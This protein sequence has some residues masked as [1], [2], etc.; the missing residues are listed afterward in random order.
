MSAEREIVNLWLNRRGFF[1]IAG[2]N[3]G[4]RVVD[5]VAIRHAQGTTEIMHVEVSCSISANALFEKDRAELKKLFY[6]PSIVKAVE[7][8]ISNF[9]GENHSYQNVLVTNFQGIEIDGVRVIKF[10]D[11]FFDFLS[12]LD[13]QRYYS[14]T[15]RGLQL[16]KFLLMSDP[17]K[18]SALLNQQTSYRPMTSSNKESL[19]KELLKQDVGKRVFRKPGNE[20]ILVEL[21]RQ[22]SLSNPERLAN[23]MEEV[24]TKRGGSRFLNLLMKKKGIREAIKEELSKDQKLEQYFKV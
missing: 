17:D 21:L 9:L 16:A 18:M 7:S 23:A 5:F 15:I 14:Q 2:I 3:T 24:L 4:S 1:T 20:Q 12:E 13:K 8:S 22:S 19:I 11:V 6:D 10:E